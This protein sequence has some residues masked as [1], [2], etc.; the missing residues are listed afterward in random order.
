MDY[1]RDTST[2]KLLR[3]HLAG[4][5]KIK[6]VYTSMPSN[7]DREIFLSPQAIMR[8][9]SSASIIN[10]VA[11]FKEVVIPRRKIDLARF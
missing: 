2:A 10:Q 3:T 4:Y 9:I 7:T 8:H 11:N 5:N 1:L 6:V